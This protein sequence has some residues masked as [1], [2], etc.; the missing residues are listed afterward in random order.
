[1]SHKTTRGRDPFAFSLRGMAAVASIIAPPVVADRSIDEYCDSQAER[2]RTLG[3]DLL[4]SPE[5]QAAPQ[6]A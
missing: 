4:S 2:S 6:R 1:M 5:G 3:A